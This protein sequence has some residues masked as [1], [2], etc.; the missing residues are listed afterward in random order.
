MEQIQITNPRTKRINDF[1]STSLFEM[2]KYNQF[3]LYKKVWDNKKQ[4]LNKI[5][6]SPIS[7]KPYKSSDGNWQENPNCTTSYLKALQK[8]RM[9]DDNY[10]VAF[11]FKSSDPFFFLDIDKCIDDE[12]CLSEIATELLEKLS[13]AAVEISLS[14]KGMHIFGTAIVPSEHLK[15]NIKLGLE[16]YTEKRIVAL[17]GIEFS[18]DVSTDCSRP[19]SEIIDKYFSPTIVSKDKKQACNIFLDVSENLCEKLDD[20]S[21]K[22]KTGHF[23]AKIKA[24]W[25]ANENILSQYYPSQT[26]ECI[27]DRSSADCALAVFLVGELGE[28]ARTIEKMMRASNLVR[29][30]WDRSDY[31]SNTINNAIGFSQTL[32][33]SSRNLNF[34][35]I[36]DREGSCIMDL[37]QQVQ[38]FKGC[39]YIL[40]IHKVFTPSGELLNKEQF[41]V[42][43]SGYFFKL[44]DETDKEENQKI[45]KTRSAWNA[46]TGSLGKNFPKA[47]S[48][49]FDPNISPGEIIQKEGFLSVNTYTPLKI[50]KKAGDSSLFVDHVKKLLPNETDQEILLSYMAACVQYKGVKFQWAPLLQGTP[51]NGKTLFSKCVSYAV[52]KLHSH[53]ANPQDITNKFNAWILRKLFISVEDI[54]MEKND[55]SAIEIIKRLITEEEL[56]VQKKGADQ[57]TVKNF[58]NF[59]FNSNHKDAVHKTKDDRRFAIFYTAQQTKED[60]QRDGMD[61]LYFKNLYHWLSQKDGYAIVADYLSNY[62]INANIDLC[63]Q[64]PETSSTQQ[65]I[66][67]G[68]GRV[69]QEIMEAIEEC[70][71]GFC[72]GWVSSVALDRLLVNIKADKLY[73][74]RKRRDLMQSL[75][76]DWHPGLKDGRTGEMIEID[77]NKRPVLY[78]KMSLDI[79]SLTSPRDIVIEYRNSQNLYNNANSRYHTI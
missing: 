4:K 6:I 21:R 73:P 45:I 62:E 51:G 36:E 54:M 32:H 5:P 14:G 1:I 67:E 15:K 30:K 38:Y 22:I 44:T 48:S 64:A 24:L 12:G 70:A 71:L 3:L 28:D 69:E 25:E 50:Y 27:Y 11:L 33:A 42:A 40:D 60:L 10:G 39:V 79:S 41:D 19:L 55:I 72:G 18:G 58:A 52:G 20:I 31:M 74:P 78:V 57:V 59:L 76:Y 29:E 2:S 49:F 56:E 61:N 53:A 26:Q 7:L 13:G 34:N 47:N 17:T 66:N 35:K 9:L 8:L 63:G 37:E 75:G 43:Y 65:A 46:F 23:G 77:E 68:L 16:L